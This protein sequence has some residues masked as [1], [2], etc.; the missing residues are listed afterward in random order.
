MLSGRQVLVPGATV[1]LGGYAARE[2]K[3]RG[4]F[5]SASI[6]IG[7]GKR[8]YEGNVMKEKPP[9]FNKHYGDCLRPLTPNHV[10]AIMIGLVCSLACAFVLT[11]LTVTGCCGET[12][13]PLEK[14]P[15]KQ[16]TVE[17]INIS[18]LDKGE[19]M[20]LV[21][22]HGIPTS[23]FLW[24]EMVGEL[25]AHGRVIA[26]DLPG[27]GFS[28]PPTGGDY[29]ISNYARLLGSFLEALSIEKGVLVCHDFGGPVTVMYALQ[30]PERYQRLIIL[31][32]FLHT[33]LPDW[34]LFYKIAKIWPVGEV[35]MG[36]AGESIVRSGLEAGVVNK[37]RITKEV[38]RRYYM[39]DGS[40][41]KLN[42][43]Y[44]STL[45]ADHIK[46][47]RFIEENLTTIDKPTLIVWG[48][49]D[50]YLPL[51]LAHRIHQDI[52]GSKIEIIPNCGHFLQ[53]DKPKKVTEIIVRFLKD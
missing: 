27:F 33:D 8:F 13:T 32:T 53:E 23:S 3:S 22:V 6:S 5:V 4:C 19:G 11:V 49:N 30:H 21:L 24:R 40:A 44:L 39:P 35:L 10:H 14:I 45:R 52:I 16:V 46:D 34:G 20:V 28:D 29:S 7:L 12:Q 51:P 31:D 9:V 1:Y 36:L 41:D 18:Y 38:V 42:K 50:V 37:S 25:T 43:T 15:M 47:L 48:E 17:G 26:P 2:F